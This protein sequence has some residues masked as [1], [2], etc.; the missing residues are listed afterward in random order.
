MGDGLCFPIGAGKPADPLPVNAA[1]PTVRDESGAIP[2]LQPVLDDLRYP[3]VRLEV[4]DPD[5]AVE[6]YPLDA[7][8]FPR[9]KLHRGLLRFRKRE[10]VSL[11]GA[12]L[13]GIVS[14]RLKA[15]SR[16]TASS[17]AL[18]ARTVGSTGMG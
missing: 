18:A 2:L 12:P 10:P 4:A 15:V 11:G 9:G 6:V 13:H 5:P 17:P 14:R 1:A 3:F 8:S 16:F 7:E